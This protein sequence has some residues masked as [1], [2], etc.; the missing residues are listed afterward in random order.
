VSPSPSELR[1]VL[2]WFLAT[3]AAL[4]VIAALSLTFLGVWLP[5]WGLRESYAPSQP[6][7]ACMGC[8]THYYLDIAQHGY[9]AGRMGPISNPDIGFFPLYPLLIH[10]GAWVIRS[11]A[12]V[13]LIISNLSLVMGAFWLYRLIRL[14]EGEDGARRCARLLFVSPLGF[15]LSAIQTEGLFFFLVVHCFYAARRGRWWAAGA[16]GFLAALTRP[17]GLALMVPLCWIFARQRGR[18][19]WPDVCSL[20]MVPLGLLVFG[21]Y[22]SLVSGDL[23]AY[24]RAQEHFQNHHLAN[25]V[26]V[27]YQGMLMNDPNVA[28]N[29]WAAYAS[30]LLL[31]ISSRH[32]RVEYTLFA[33]L[34][35]LAGPLTGTAA[36]TLR[37]LSPLFPL[38]LALSRPR[39]GEEGDRIFCAVLLLLQGCLMVLWVGG[40]YLLC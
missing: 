19:I 39:L 2:A 10:A 29:A 14:D 18:R 4:L 9:R 33:V 13:G 35:I 24:E 7:G 27:L 38:V 31:L 22:G 34:V 17:T 6:L 23:F 1:Q 40:F 30:L 28:I 26:V 32:L 12:A 25:P 8:D 3:R 36:G 20:L 5:G 21:A 11:E 15:F 37:Y 16:C